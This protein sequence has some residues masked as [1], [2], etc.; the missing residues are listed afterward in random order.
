MVGVAK[1]AA[2]EQ[3]RSTNHYKNGIL[4]ILSDREANEFI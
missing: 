3:Q 1:E 4:G 2:L